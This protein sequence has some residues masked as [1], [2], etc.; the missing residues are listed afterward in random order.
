MSGKW[1]E[2]CAALYQVIGA[3]AAYTGVFETKDIEDALDVAAGRGD[4]ESLLPWP[5][6]LERFNELGKKK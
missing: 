1:E 3:L 4:L 5:K 6:D 2:R